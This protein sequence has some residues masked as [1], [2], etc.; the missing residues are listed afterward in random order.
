MSLTGVE[1][2]HGTIENIKK[3]IKPN[4]VLVVISDDEGKVR[5][6]KVDHPSIPTDQPFLKITAGSSPDT[7]QAQGGCW[8]LING[9]LVWVN[10]CV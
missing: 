2:P 9:Q 3:Y 6:A 10:P 4:M 8:K 7:A 5:V 1:V